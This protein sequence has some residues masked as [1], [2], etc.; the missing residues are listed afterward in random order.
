MEEGVI[1]ERRGLLVKGGCYWLEEGV[2]GERRALRLSRAG[3]VKGDTS[4]LDP[5]SDME[6]LNLPPG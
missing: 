5:A 1:G 2:I 6:C 4:P 3:A